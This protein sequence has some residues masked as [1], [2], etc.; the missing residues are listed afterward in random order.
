VK[1]IAVAKSKVHNRMYSFTTELTSLAE[2]G[3]LRPKRTVLLYIYIY[4]YVY[5]V[6][7][8]SSFEL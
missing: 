2:S 6:R 3:R 1:E 8:F 5:Y 7:G 4:M